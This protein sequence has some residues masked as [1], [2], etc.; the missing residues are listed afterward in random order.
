MTP[1]IM[2]DAVRAHLAVLYNDVRCSRAPKAMPASEL[3]LRGRLLM[4][5]GDALISAG[6][7]LRAHGR[8]ARLPEPAR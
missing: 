3:G 6:V 1:T 8:P 4:S 2:R 7:W 5:A